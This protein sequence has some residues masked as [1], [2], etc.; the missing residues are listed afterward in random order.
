[1]GIE[2]MFGTMVSTNLGCTQTF[3]LSPFAAYLDIDGSLLVKSPQPPG[4]VVWGTGGRVEAS[5]LDFGLSVD[6]SCLFD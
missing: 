2:M 6:G 1:M 4:G 3:Q 5:H